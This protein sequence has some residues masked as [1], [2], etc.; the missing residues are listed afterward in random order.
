MG[1][2]EV[3]AEVLEH[4]REIWGEDALQVDAKSIECSDVNDSQSI[5]LIAGVNYLLVVNKATHKCTS[6][7]SVELVPAG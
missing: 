6:D 1:G 2:F 5:L 7:Q 4:V 3:V